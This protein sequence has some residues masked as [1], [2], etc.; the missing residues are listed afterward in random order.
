MTRAERRILVLLRQLAGRD[1]AVL[2][3]L[4]GSPRR[5]AVL[6]YVAE[7]H[8]FRYAETHRVGRALQVHVVRE[9]RADP[10]PP[11]SAAVPGLRSGTLRPLPEAAQAVRQLRDRIELDALAENMSVRTRS[12]IMTACALLVGLC[13]LVS[14]WRAALAG[15][16]AMEAVFTGFLYLE[17]VRRRKLARRV[18]AA[19]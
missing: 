8:G 15:F 14:G 11:D 13:L 5:L 1:F 3:D 17:V 7:Q 4:G 12:V 9:E 16:A 19:A 2:S 6:T 10:R 18:H